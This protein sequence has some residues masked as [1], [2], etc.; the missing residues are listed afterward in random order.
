MNAIWQNAV[1]ALVVAYCAYGAL[2]QLLPRA[3]QQNINAWGWQRRARLSFWLEHRASI[4]LR[5]L[6]FWLRPPI[7]MSASCGT[8]AGCNKCGSC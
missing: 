4:H 1:V 8:G 7:T 2:R 5:R 3:M 6:G